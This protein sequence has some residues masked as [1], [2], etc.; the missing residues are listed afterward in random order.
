MR[1]VIFIKPLLLALLLLFLSCGENQIEN[2]HGV[3][4]GFMQLNVNHYQYIGIGGGE[5][6]FFEYYTQ[7]GEEIGSRKW[8][9]NNAPILNFDYEW[10]YR[11]ELIVNKQKVDPP[12]IDYPK[13]EYEL[14][15]V[16]S[17]KK[18]ERDE[19]FRIHI[20]PQTLTE[21]KKEGF[22]LLD[23]V[24]IDCQ[25]LCNELADIQRKNISATGTFQ[26]QSE[27]KISLV[28]LEIIKID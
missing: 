17:K 18:V 10:G 25:K 22:L 21:N 12:I 26:H 5:G 7:E 14:I 24:G 23:S 13:Y 20:Y 6:L 15:K 3:L 19:T 28:S 16:V 11:Y 2:S 9:F 27:K 4:L 8:S 1:K